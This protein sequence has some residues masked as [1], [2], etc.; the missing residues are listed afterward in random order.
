MKIGFSVHNKLKIGFIG[1]SPLE[2][3]LIEHWCIKP[4]IVVKTFSNFSPVADKIMKYADETMFFY[5][6]KT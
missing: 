5:K 4:E 2:A 6:F 1:N 3:Q